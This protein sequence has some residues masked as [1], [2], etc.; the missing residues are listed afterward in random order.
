MRY[1]ELS[2]EER[3]RLR[4][5]FD[6][7]FS[8]GTCWASTIP[9]DLVELMDAVHD[10]WFRSLE[11]MQEAQRARYAFPDIEWLRAAC[12]RESALGDARPPESWLTRSAKEG[13]P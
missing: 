9:D 2:L 5:A 12:E 8:A 3:D 11:T 4:A 7:G 10:D 1:D 6:A 13:R